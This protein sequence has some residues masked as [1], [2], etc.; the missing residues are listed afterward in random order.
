MTGNGGRTVQTNLEGSA[1]AAAAAQA[2]PT[3]QPRTSSPV[4]STQ[5][6]EGSPPSHSPGVPPVPPQASQPGHP[7]VIRISHQTVEPVVMM[8]MNIQGEFGRPDG[9]IRAIFGGYTQ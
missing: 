3:A 7:R 1:A 4:E 5:P 2:A 6:S 8:H 9:E